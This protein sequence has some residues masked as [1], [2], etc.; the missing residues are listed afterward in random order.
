MRRHVK[1][2]TFSTRVP[3]RKAAMS[4]T[5]AGRRTF[6]AWIDAAAE[7]PAFSATAVSARVRDALVLR[8]VRQKKSANPRS[9]F[10]GP[11]AR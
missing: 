11:G 6:P 5:A 10:D 9:A 8:T 7:G 2:K 4:A 3:L 1:V